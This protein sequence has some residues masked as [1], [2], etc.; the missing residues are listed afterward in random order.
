VSQEQKNQVAE[1]VS[2]VPQAS[3]L[4]PSTVKAVEETQKAQ[5]GQGPEEAAGSVSS[6][7]TAGTTVAP[8]KKRSKRKTR[9]VNVAEISPRPSYWPILLALSLALVL[10]GVIAGPVVVAVGIILALVSVGGW[11]LER[12]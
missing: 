6:V 7:D 4:P 12:R 11:I 10:F 1:G 5:E 2:S 3:P 9:L 8:A